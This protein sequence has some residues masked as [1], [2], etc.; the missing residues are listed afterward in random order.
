VEKK[1]LMMISRNM[2]LAEKMK[3]ESK[4]PVDIKVAD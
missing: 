3:R 2:E 1:P 4:A